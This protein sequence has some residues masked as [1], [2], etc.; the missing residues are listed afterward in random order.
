[1]LESL[2]NVSFFIPVL[3]RAGTSLQL[4]ACI[5]KVLPPRAPCG[6]PM[7]KQSAINEEAAKPKCRN[8]GFFHSGLCG[9]IPMWNLWRRNVL[10]YLQI[11][12]VL[13]NAYKETTGDNETSLS[14]T[15]QLSFS[16]SLA[17]L[18]L[19]SLLFPTPSNQVLLYS[20]FLIRLEREVETVEAQGRRLGGKFTFKLP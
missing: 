15:L 19:I 2:G 12:D 3:L 4:Q 1:M 9:E 11:V 16:P 8:I 13:M 10:V 6:W 17:L 18:H 14:E 7:D 5:S 20:C